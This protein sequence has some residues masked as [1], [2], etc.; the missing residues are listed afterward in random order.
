VDRGRQQ[1]RLRLQ[2]FSDPP[3]PPIGQHRYTLTD[4]GRR[5]GVF[6]TK[7]AN[8]IVAPLFATDHPNTPA[9]LRRALAT[10]DASPATT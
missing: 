9:T 7:L 2:Q 4:D 10:I 8:R 1:R 5:F 6:Y 3:P